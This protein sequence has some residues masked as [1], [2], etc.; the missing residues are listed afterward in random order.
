MGT[1][2]AGFRT[3]MGAMRTCERLATGNALLRAALTYGWDV[4]DGVSAQAFPDST[5]LPASWPAIQMSTPWSANSPVSPSKMTWLQY[6]KLG[7]GKYGSNEEDPGY[8]AAPCTMFHAAPY[9]RDM[10]SAAL[11]PNLALHFGQSATPISVVYCS[12][13]GDGSAGAYG[14]KQCT[15]QMHG[16]GMTVT[17]MVSG[18][19]L[20]MPYR[21]FGVTHK[22][23]V[24]AA[25]LASAPGPGDRL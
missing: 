21:V 17:D 19:T 4:A 20:E 18:R 13:P 12:S 23:A 11:S 10:P 15:M 1:A 2:F 9:G 22:P 7:P 3:A 8:G 14:R 24:S 5:Q 25:D 16:V 6:G